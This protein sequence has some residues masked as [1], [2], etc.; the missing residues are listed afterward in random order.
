MSELA[1]LLDLD[2]TTL[3]RNVAPLE[4][5]GLVEIGPGE[6][7]RSRTARITEAGRAAREAALPHWRRAQM[8]VMTLLGAERLASLHALLDDVLGVVRDAGGDFS[9]TPS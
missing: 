1:D 6:D 5:R 2:R 3:T 8:A 4:A 9:E 7:A